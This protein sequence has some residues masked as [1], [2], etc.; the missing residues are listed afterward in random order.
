MRKINKIKVNSKCKP[1]LKSSRKRSLI[2]KTKIRK[3]NLLRMRVGEQ[4]GK[5]ET[6]KIK[7]KRKNP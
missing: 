4:M 1:S 3:N 6:K 7:L 5:W 2:T